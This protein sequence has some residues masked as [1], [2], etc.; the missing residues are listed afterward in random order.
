MSHSGSISEV[1]YSDK[2]FDYLTMLK[3]A[4][5]MAKGINFLHRCILI[6]KRSC[7]LDPLVTN[8]FFS[9][10]GVMHRDVKPDN[11]LVTKFIFQLL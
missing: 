11:F 5:D 7:I 9:S 1:V 10:N 3:V 2:P 6:S 4:M 8:S